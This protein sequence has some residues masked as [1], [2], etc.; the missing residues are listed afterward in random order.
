MRH[1]NAVEAVRGRRCRRLIGEVE[2]VG[3]PGRGGGQAGRYIRS[4]CSL[5]REPQGEACFPI[6]PLC[7]ASSDTTIDRDAHFR[8]F[9]VKVTL[10]QRKKWDWV[11][12]L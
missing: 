7:A 11:R 4:V 10:A 12:V 3:F 2:K 1:R 6:F 8:Q 9:L 5:H